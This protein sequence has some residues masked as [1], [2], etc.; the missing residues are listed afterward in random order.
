M[1]IETLKDIKAA[2]KN[3]P[4][5]VL[6]NYGVGYNEEGDMEVQLLCF[7]GD[8]EMDAVAMFVKDTKKFPQLDLIGEW[9]E[10]IAE[11]GAKQDS[12]DEDLS[13]LNQE[14]PMFVED[15]KKA[16]KK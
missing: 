11:M 4:D 16:K 8:D 9:I 7:G 5:D 15:K 2:L 14:G 1:R 10:K 6:D 13:D 3:I 12:Q